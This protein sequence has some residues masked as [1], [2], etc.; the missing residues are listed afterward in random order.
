MDIQNKV[1]LILGA[2]GLVGNA[3]TK[4]LLPHKPKQIIVTSLKQN[5]AE[6]Y[7]AQL[8]A[9]NPNLPDDYFI[10]WWGNIFVRNE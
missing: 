4:K 9:E 10:P 7:V 6:D 3:V 2:W 5:E 8:K 1:V